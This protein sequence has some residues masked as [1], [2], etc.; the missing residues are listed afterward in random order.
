MD[1]ISKS[2]VFSCLVFCLAVI[3]AYPPLRMDDITLSQNIQNRL[4]TNA[5]PTERIV[6]TANQGHIALAGS[7]TSQEEA[8]KAIEIAA[9]TPG[10][11]DV[12]VGSLVV[13]GIP[14]MLSDNAITAQVNG[15]LFREKLFGDSRSPDVRISAQTKNHI[16][17]LTGTAT[18]RRQINKALSLV[19]AVAGVSRAEVQVEI[20]K[21]QERSNYA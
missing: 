13:N 20:K 16:V 19:Q 5:S 4:L 9:A 11:R 17:Y 21:W 1:A 6:I 3:L 8:N 10:V 18:D 15:A 12:Q 7:L 14:V 2:V